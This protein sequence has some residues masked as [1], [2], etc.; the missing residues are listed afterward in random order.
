MEGK[1]TIINK[2]MSDADSQA[3]EI[4]AQAKAKAEAQVKKAL[5]E[6]EALQADAAK[7]AEDA[8]SE[9]ITRRLTVAGLDVKK[10]MLAVKKELIDASF[11]KAESVLAGLEDD[12]YLKLISAMLAKSASDGD[13]V[14]VSAK[15][16]SR[17]TADF[18]KKQSKKLGISL[19]LGKEYGD[20]DGGIILTGGGVDKNL[21][22]E[23]EL[24]LLYDEIQAYVAAILFKETENA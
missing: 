4:L 17:I 21:T 22:L 13:T 2:I 15:D 14:T 12:D 7:K 6:S 9:L 23:V 5:D 20:F 16:K 8:G 11:A 3:E 18:I 19:T 24:K 1:D 10:Q